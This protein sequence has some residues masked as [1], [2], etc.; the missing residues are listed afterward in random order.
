M[1]W[2]QSTYTKV[3]RYPVEFTYVSQRETDTGYVLELQ[4]KSTGGEP[5]F[6]PREDLRVRIVRDARLVEAMA[7]SQRNTLVHGE[8]VKVLD[9]AATL[10]AEIDGRTY[11][12]DPNMACTTQSRPLYLLLRVAGPG[13]TNPSLRLQIAPVY[14]SLAV[15]LQRRFRTSYYLEIPF[16]RLSIIAEDHKTRVIQK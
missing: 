11:T 16:R 13:S 2:T 15:G 3:F 6:I 7:P 12:I 10:A 14:R 9:N 4:V 1:G 5:V 8:T